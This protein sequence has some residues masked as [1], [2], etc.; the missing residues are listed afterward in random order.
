VS[1]DRE[2]GRLDLAALEAAVGPDTAAVYMENPNFFG[3]F[4]DRVD[5]IRAISPNV[6]IVGV[7]PLS[8]AVARAP[9]DYGADI[10][11]GEG[12][13][14]GNSVAFGGPLL[15]ILACTEDH[16]RKMPGRVIGMTRDADGRRAFCMT[17]QSREQHIRREKAMSNIC[18]NETLL[19]VASAAYIAVLGANG[20]RRVAQE[21]IERARTLAARIGKV[22]GFH[23]PAFRTHHF[24]EFVVR[25][26]RPYERV[27]E[28]LL[29]AGVHGGLPL[30][31]RFPELGHAALFATTEVHREGEYDAL[32]H[33]LEAMR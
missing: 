9:G 19:A 12:Q 2:T 31:A 24:N 5:E 13:S 32:V 6:L 4:D 14:L 22:R 23:A 20:L 18:T 27:H 3:V 7:N 10:V 11:I 30:E 16:I 28:A 8:L 17:M 33:A 25:S 21:N 1:F 26:D 15:G 29:A